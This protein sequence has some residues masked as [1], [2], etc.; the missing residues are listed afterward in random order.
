MR[1]CVIAPS[2]QYLAQ[3]GVRIRY[4]RI[5]GRL[6]ALGHT[7]TIQV[8]DE[9]RGPGLA[10]HDVYLF[11]K[12]YDARAFAVAAS[13]KL[14]G[15]QVGV[16]FFDDYF[17]QHADS[18]FIRMRE[19]VRT[20]SGFA[21]YFL[22]STPR[23]R[24]VMASYMPGKPSHVMNDPFD[25][26]DAEA[27]GRSIAEK[28]ERA[29]ATGRLDILW[30][31]MG[32]NPHFPVGLDDLAAF[33][34]TLK[35]LDG[36]PYEVRLRVLTNK[37][38]LGVRGLELLGRLPV[39]HSLEEWSEAREAEALAAS[40]AAFIPVNGQSFSIAKSLNRAVSALSAGVQILSSGYPLYAGLEPLVY[41]RPEALLADV[42]R[43]ELALRAETTPLL[44]GLFDTLGDPARE[45]ARYAEFLEGVLAG[46]PPS[47]P[48]V[49][50][51]PPVAIIH[52]KRSGGDCHKLVQRL[53]HLSV[54][55][56]MSPRGLNYDLQFFPA[57]DGAGIDVDI[58]AGALAR[59]PIREAL[60]P[61]LI[62][63]TSAS[64]KPFHRLRLAEVAP[65]AGSLPFRWGGADPEL[66][67][68]VRYGA[69]LAAVRSVLE[70]LYPGVTACLSEQESGYWED[71]TGGPHGRMLAEKR[72]A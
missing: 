32:D 68:L 21:D 64:G 33:G 52:G 28:L 62:P 13:L 41:T 39:A 54:A 3:A 36:G 6:E 23:M 51:S 55:T 50:G 44:E 61:H 60:E 31:G 15:K 24:E 12:C 5:A 65:E 7:L 2:Q 56:P 53:G 40:L 17:S 20:M 66:G 71:P 34:H 27:V 37:R 14:G 10:E 67:K 57:A 58:S 43:G 63:V 48:A 4:Q 47:E 1:I 59:S 46:A 70:R 35:R 69:T 42:E 26:F 18:R 16:D 11:S 25:A 30:F 22:C 8:I 45:A 9:L 49:V 38:A 29:R 19:W 72:S